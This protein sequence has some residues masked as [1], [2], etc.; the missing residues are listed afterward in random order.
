MS[1]VIIFAFVKFN[2]AIVNVKIDFYGLRYEF[3]LLG[4]DN[5]PNQTQIQTQTQTQT[6][7]PNETLISL[8]TPPE[9]SPTSNHDLD[10]IV[11][12]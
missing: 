11:I 12:E 1:I 3:F 8:E 2:Y 7:T 4:I 9:Q 5:F 6:Q 10:D